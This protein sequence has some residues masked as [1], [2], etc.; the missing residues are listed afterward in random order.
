MFNKIE[1]V[2]S[3]PMQQTG[4]RY[5]FYNISDK[6]IITK[7]PYQCTTN[8]CIITNGYFHVCSIL[9]L[10]LVFDLKYAELE[11][12]IGFFFMI[13]ITYALPY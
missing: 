3:N 5:W 4:A 12:I 9:K 1:I 10:L 2:I 13:I 6:L 11:D 8:F 7:L